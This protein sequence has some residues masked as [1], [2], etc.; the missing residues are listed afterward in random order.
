MSTERANRLLFAL[1]SITTRVK[2][3]RIA[4]HRLMIYQRL[5]HQAKSAMASKSGSWMNHLISGLLCTVKD[6]RNRAITFGTEAGLRLGGSATVSQAFSTM[7]NH[8]SPD[9]RRVVELLCARMQE[10]AASR[11][12]GQQVPQMWSVAILFL[13]SRRRQVECWDHIKAW[14]D[15]LEKCF[16][17]T[18]AQIKFQANLAW[19]H[20]I[21]CV[22]IDMSTSSSM[23]KMLKAPIVAQLERK[24]NE[25]PVE[26]KTKLIKQV[27]RSSYCTLLYYAL[28][29]GVSYAQ[30]D[31]YWDLYVADVLTNSISRTGADVNYACEILAALLF[32]DGQPRLWN[33]NRANMIGPTTS[34]ELPCLDPK[35]IRSRVGKVIQVFGRLFD[36]ADWAVNEGRSAHIVIAWQ[37]FMASLGSAG[38][39]EVK[40]S[41]D[42]MVAIAQI[43]NQVQSLLSKAGEIQ[44]RASIYEHVGV[45]LHE[46]LSKIGAL[47]FNEKRLALTTQS[48]FEAVPE[49]PS[50]RL[51]NSPVELNSA[52]VHLLRLLLQKPI[53]YEHTACIDTIKKIVQVAL[54]SS[55]TRQGRLSTLRGVARLCASDCDTVPS[56]SRLILW[57]VIA[58][59]GISTLQLQRASDSHDRSSQH[60]GHE[61]RDTA[62]ILE[63]A[64]HH[65]SMH[66]FL[67]WQKL[68]DRLVETL[69]QEVGPAAIML[70]VY[71]PLTG[72]I[73][74]ELVQKHDEFSLNA[75]VKIIERVQWVT[76][77]HS[78]E[79][80]HMQLWGAIQGHHKSIP[81]DLPEDMY[82]L[83]TTSLKQ[84]YAVVTSLP[85]ETASSL[86]SAVT[87]LVHS[88]PSDLKAKLLVKVHYGVA[89]WIEDQVGALSGL[90]KLVLPKV[91]LL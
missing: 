34:K 88:C 40:V 91:R 49:T 36:W 65:Q 23:A 30:L 16:N 53:S 43:V 58:D 3:T 52:A 76:D 78:L 60:P 86:L 68:Y 24:Q 61:Y 19:N 9:G 42:T 18:D 56:E 5:L 74:R 54:E 25:K 80:T 39:K 26:K 69:R 21:F 70:V 8:Q 90:D 32:N 63:I 64:F 20:L 79:R 73:Q 55:H 17:S 38:S 62:K 44:S 87:S 41:S 72:F 1:D 81:L 66:N 37:S 14:L 89:L 7:L 11:E 84:G 67:T 75:A 51:K 57:Q 47:A 10:M 82:S 83:I 35:W 27:A 28:R 46:A 29:P 33:N 12:D 15:V 77:R 71:E 2:G 48:A 59:A 50:S 6:I 4:G 45:L 22:D 31:Q 13:R 85:P